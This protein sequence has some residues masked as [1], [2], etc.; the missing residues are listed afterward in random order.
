MYG[1]SVRTTTGEN[2]IQL[3]EHCS[4]ECMWDDTQ[5]PREQEKSENKETEECQMSKSG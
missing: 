5:T 3:F 2:S 1:C 4:W